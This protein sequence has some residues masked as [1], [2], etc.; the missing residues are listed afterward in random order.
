[1]HRQG[2]KFKGNTLPFQN[3]RRKLVFLY[4][5]CKC[6]ESVLKAA[7]SGFV[8]I[9]EPPVRL[10][11]GPER[12]FPG[13]QG[14]NSKVGVQQEAVQLHLRVHPRQLFPEALLRLLQ[15]RQAASGGRLLVKQTRQYL[16]GG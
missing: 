8:Q 9:A 13:H 15:E 10:A 4:A 11:A 6:K 7:S 14:G 5:V 1:M 2:G 12:Q 16:P 3:D